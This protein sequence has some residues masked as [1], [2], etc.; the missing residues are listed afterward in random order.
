MYTHTHTQRER[1]REV[2]I[3]NALPEEGLDSLLL[4]VTTAA[5]EGA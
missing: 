3:G 5:R 1:E 4:S 2:N